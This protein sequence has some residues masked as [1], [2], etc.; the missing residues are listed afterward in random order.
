MLE[1]ARQI[2]ERRQPAQ[3]TAANSR[4]AATTPDPPTSPAES[5]YVFTR[6]FPDL[7]QRVTAEFKH[8]VSVHNAEVK[9]TAVTV[10][11]GSADAISIRKAT[12]PSAYLDILPRHD[13]GTYTAHFEFYRSHLATPRTYEETGRFQAVGDDL[14][15]VWKGRQR[16]AAEFVGDMMGLFFEGI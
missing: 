6:R 14:T 2:A 4:E 5:S 7:W 12:F 10:Q 8:A 1:W 3:D 16:T 9:D 15:I 13:R 11:V